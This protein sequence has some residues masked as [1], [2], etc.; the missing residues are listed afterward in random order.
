MPPI[1][2]PEERP[3]LYE[4]DIPEDRELSKD[5]VARTMPDHV[6][7]RIAERAAKDAAAPSV[8]PAPDQRP[9]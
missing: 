7:K 6:K 5:Y 3:D 1:P 4:N 8:N 2:S 9:T